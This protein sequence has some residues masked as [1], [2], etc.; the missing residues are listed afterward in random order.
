MTHERSSADLRCSENVR[1][2]SA[3]NGSNELKSSG[4]CLYGFQPGRQS[5]KPHLRFL[6]PTTKRLRNISQ[7]R[8]DVRCRGGGQCIG[9]RKTR[10]PCKDRLTYPKISNLVDF[11][12]AVLVKYHVGTLLCIQAVLVLFSVFFQVQ[13]VQLIV[14]RLF[15]QKICS[16]ENESIN[17]YISI[18]EFNLPKHFNPGTRYCL[19]QR[20]HY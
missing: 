15:Y 10:K 6:Q 5:P 20:Q 14:G 1:D 16:S 8:I 17:L 13:E 12:Y 11:F 18:E 2:P 7:L 4:V 3:T 9:Y 19:Q